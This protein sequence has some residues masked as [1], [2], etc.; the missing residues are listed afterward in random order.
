[1]AKKLMLFP[2]LFEDI[3]PFLVF[4]YAYS[5]EQA[6]NYAIKTFPELE[7]STMVTSQNSIIA[8]QG[9]SFLV[10]AEMEILFNNEQLSFWYEDDIENIDEKDEKTDE[11]EVEGKS[12][13]K[14]TDNPDESPRFIWA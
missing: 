6:M 7:T 14:S 3:M 10:D 2:I 8:S 1:M 13:D 4:V 11:D 5:L 9:K 12:D